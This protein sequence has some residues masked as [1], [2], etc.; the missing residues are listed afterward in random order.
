MTL[1]AVSM[2]RRCRPRHREC[3]FGGFDNHED[4]CGQKKNSTGSTVIDRVAALAFRSCRKPPGIPC[5]CACVPGSGSRLRSTPNGDHGVHA[6]EN[7]STGG[8]VLLRFGCGGRL[9]QRYCSGFV[10][11]RARIVDCVGVLRACDGVGLALFD[12]AFS[13]DPCPQRND[14]ASTPVNAAITSKSASR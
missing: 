14:R 2:R 1:T 9:R 3:R 8:H 11:V 4:R 12:D 10:D 5:P 7:A 6:A 13:Q